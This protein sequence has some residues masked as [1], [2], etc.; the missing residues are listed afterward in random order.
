VDELEGEKSESH[1]ATNGNGSGSSIRF[2]G[3]R[4]ACRLRH[5]H[6]ALGDLIPWTLT[7][8]EENRGCSFLLVE[9]PIKI[10][11]HPHQQQ[12]ITNRGNVVPRVGRIH[13]RD[14]QAIYPCIHASMTNFYK[15]QDFFH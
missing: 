3:R 10:Q 2:L 8:P 6:A 13:P 9:L 7:L 15:L 11:T 12:E 14:A 5:A 1:T 4:R